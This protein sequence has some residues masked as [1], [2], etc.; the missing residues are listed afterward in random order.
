MDYELIFYYG[1][2]VSEVIFLGKNH[3]ADKYTYD[4]YLSLINNHIV[5]SVWFNNFAEDELIHGN[6]IVDGKSLCFEGET[7]SGKTTTLFII[8]METNKIQLLTE[9][10]FS[11]QAKIN[12]L[13]NQISKEDLS[14]FL[15]NNS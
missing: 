15:D 6:V 14:R 1:E 7:D 11:N 13:I 8:T 5:F 2:K 4:H 3:L 12:K 9:E 10:E